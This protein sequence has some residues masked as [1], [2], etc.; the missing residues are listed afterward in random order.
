MGEAKEKQ[1]LLSWVLVAHTCNST[2]LGAEN[3]K[4]KA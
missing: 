4:V 3:G 1:R 2:Y